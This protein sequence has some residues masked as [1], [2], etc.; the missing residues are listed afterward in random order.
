MLSNF[1]FEPT[2]QH[3]SPMILATLAGVQAQED[4]YDMYD[5]VA[6]LDG[7][8]EEDASAGFMY[9]HPGVDTTVLFQ[10]HPDKRTFQH[11]HTHNNN[12]STQHTHC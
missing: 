1:L 7:F 4:E 9:T 6:E 5:D 2:N 3:P 8:E 12:H 10:T 11:T